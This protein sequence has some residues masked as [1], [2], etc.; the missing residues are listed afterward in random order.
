M[1]RS[2]RELRGL[3]SVTGSYIQVWTDIL[4][5]PKTHDLDDNLFAGWVKLLLVAK[6]FK[7]DGKLPGGKIIAFWT[8]QDGAIVARWLRDLEDR[9]FLDRDDDNQLSIHDWAALAIAHE[10]R[11]DNADTANGA[12]LPLDSLL[13]KTET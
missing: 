6:K 4:D 11:N 13:T 12:S 9:G 3:E 8:H 10:P 7:H 2:K 5:S 1:P